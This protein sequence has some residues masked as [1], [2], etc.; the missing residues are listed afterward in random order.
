MKVF[1]SESGE[2]SAQIKHRLQ[3]RSKQIWLY[4]NVRDNMRCT[5]SLEEALLWIMELY[6]SKK[7]FM[8]SLMFLIS[9]LDSHSDGTHSLQSIHCWDTD[10]ETLILI[11]DGLRASTF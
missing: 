1:W 7:V 4:F 8:D 3:N 5:F 9:C 6:L 10:E 2:K 11:L